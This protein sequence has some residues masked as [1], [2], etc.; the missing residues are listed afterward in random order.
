MTESNLVLYEF[1][2]SHY[3]EKVRW[4]LDWKGLQAT[5]STLLPGL[6]ERTTRRLTPGHTT[7]PVLCHDAAAVGD[8]G[9]FLEFL[10]T[11]APIPGLFPDAA[12]PA[13][14][15]REWVE[16]LDREVGPA[17]RLALF[18]ECFQ[19]AGFS[20]RMFT[21]SPLFMPCFFPPEIPFDLPT[22]GSPRLDAWLAT[23]R[24]QPGADY[25]RRLWA[26]HRRP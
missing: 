10:E 6:H 2:F 26:T 14:E 21:A 25:I 11:H 7:M 3:S 23:W 5:R 20:A 18:Q 16:W 9:A 15:V 8:S 13:A 19:D 1:A 12:R 24:D 17:V 22:P 4:A